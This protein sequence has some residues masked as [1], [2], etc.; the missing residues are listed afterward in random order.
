MLLAHR[1]QQ[2]DERPARPGRLGGDDLDF[3]HADGQRELRLHGA[4]QGG[5]GFVAGVPGQ[6]VQPFFAD[7]L[8]RRG[9]GPAEDFRLGRHSGLC[10]RLSLRRAGDSPQEGRANRGGRPGGG[11]PAK[12]SLQRPER[13]ADRGRRRHV[14]QLFRPRVDRAGDAGTVGCVQRTRKAPDAWAVRFTHPTAP[15][16]CPHPNPLPEGEGTDRIRRARHFSVSPRRSTMVPLIGRNLCKDCNYD[17]AYFRHRR[18][19]QFAGKGAHQRLDRHVVGA[20]RT[21]GPHAKA[22]SRISTSIRAR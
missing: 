10:G 9:A 19:G 5:L 22:R 2:R 3:D 16:Q 11:V 12:P 8:Q 6:V 1:T 15:P 7:P 4:D 13:P 14:D 20:T 21:A 17:Q 18:G